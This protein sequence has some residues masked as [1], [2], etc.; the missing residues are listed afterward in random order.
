MAQVFAGFT[1]QHREIRLDIVAGLS[2]ELTRRYR[3]GEFDIVIVKEPSASSDHRASYPEAMAWFESA[4]APDA[5]P[6]P[7]PL[8]TFP[9]GGLYRD[10]MFERIER[11][12]HRW[13]IALSSSS[14]HNVVVAVEAGLGL[15][16]LPIG[17]TAGRR[18]RPYAPFGTEPAMVVSIYSWE[19]GGLIAE[20]V[21]AM[22]AVL[23]QRY[24]IPGQS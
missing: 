20:L 6:E 21:S 3:A 7:L 8:V 12:R 1:R 10:A 9:P 14:L 2:R 22:S 16:L 23:A 11:E 4:D 13:Y 17:T 5:W 18:V 15:S 24:G 19:K